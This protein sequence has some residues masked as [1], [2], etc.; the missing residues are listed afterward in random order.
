M[1]PPFNQSA[2]V[3]RENR[4]PPRARHLMLSGFPYKYLVVCDVLYELERVG[5][6]EG[7]H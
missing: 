1:R 5:C 2:Y 6:D 7:H 3:R 4:Q